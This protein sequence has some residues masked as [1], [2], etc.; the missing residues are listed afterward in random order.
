M[1]R[2]G[3]GKKSFAIPIGPRAL[4]CFVTRDLKMGERRR[5]RQ[6][7]F[8]CEFAIFQSSS[9]L[10]QLAYD[11]FKCMRIPLKLNP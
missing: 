1:G 4:T 7:R 2:K 9:R 11:F 8:K 5:Q 6:R 3:R 10:A